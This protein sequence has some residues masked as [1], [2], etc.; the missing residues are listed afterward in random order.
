MASPALSYADYVKAAF[1]R[2]VALPLLGALPA[3]KMML[4]VFAVLG[5]ANPGF[6]L[7]GAAVEVAYLFGLAGSPRFRKLVDG[8]RL[9]RL[10]QGWDG[11][12]HD[13]VERLIP[14]SQERYRRLLDQCRRILGIS[15][16]LESDSLGGLR[17]MR[18]QSLNQL[19]WIF[20]RLL[21]SRQV[22]L[23]NVKEL[24]GPALEREIEQLEKR[25][26]GIESGT[27]EALRRSLEGTL[28]IRRKRLEN[29]ER[30]TASLRVTEAEL[31][32]IEQQVELIR[33]ETAVGGKPEFLSARLDAVTSSMTEASRWMDENSDLFSALG[34]EGDRAAMAD[35]PSL[36][37]ALE[38]GP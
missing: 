12:V 8:E 26:A 15:A 13:A 32:R 38:E 3:N 6:W 23:S 2:R 19:L 25:L 14:P 31:E 21:T 7:L 5:L 22:I 9:L 29:L 10:Q 16:T 24:D 20:L 33:E 37:P 27:G 36:P 1:H 4:G 35:L 28:E 34:D 17:D 11:R 18:G 30:A